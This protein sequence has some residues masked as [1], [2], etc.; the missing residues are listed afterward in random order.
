[1]P[2]LISNAFA[3]PAGFDILSLLP[4]FLIFV[5]FYFLIFRPQQKKTKTHQEMIKNIKKGDR[6]VTAS[7]FYATVDKVINEQEIQL[8]IADGVKVHFLKSMIHEIVNKTPL[9]IISTKKGKEEGVEKEIDSSK[10]TSITK[11]SNRKKKNSED[12]S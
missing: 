5:V 9:A 6:I 12:N 3:A 7:G 10:V 1:M 2:S 8:E 4:I 11:Q